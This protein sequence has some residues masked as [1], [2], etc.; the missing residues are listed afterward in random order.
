M[1]RYAE[2]TEKI[3]EFPAHVTRVTVGVTW[4]KPPLRTSARS[5]VFDPC[6]WVRTNL[7]VGVFFR[8]TPLHELSTEPRVNLGFSAQTAG[9]RVR[10]G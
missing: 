4:R 2:F 7:S 3:A 10:A 6:S 5:P 1:N 9:Y 8:K